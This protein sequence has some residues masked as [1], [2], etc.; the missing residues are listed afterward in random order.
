MLFLLDPSV[1]PVRFIS[2]GFGYKD[3]DQVAQPAHLPLIITLMLIFQGCG[4]W[5]V[6][7]YG[8]LNNISP[9]ILEAA[10]LDGARAGQ[11]AWHVKMPLIRPWLGYLALMN[12]AYGV[13]LFL[14]PSVLGEVTHGLIPSEW[15][16]NELTYTYAYRILDTGGAAALS[17]ILLIVTGL[18]GLLVVT[19]TN[20]LGE[21]ER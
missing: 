1:S 8:G 11:I 9:E 3:L 21:G 12:I 19:R 2:H 6:V 16:P 17:V 4:T 14:E 10:T 7:V 15:S 20:L 18:I 13:Q 5:I